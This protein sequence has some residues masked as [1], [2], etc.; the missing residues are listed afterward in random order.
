[1]SNQR[2]SSIFQQKPM[3]SVKNCQFSPAVMT[4][5][6]IALQTFVSS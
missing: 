3:I 2:A 1:M 5:L 6:V 4:N